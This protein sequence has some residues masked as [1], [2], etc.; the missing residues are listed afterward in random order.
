M[1]RQGR[2]LRNRDRRYPEPACNNCFTKEPIGKGTGKKQHRQ[3]SINNIVVKAKREAGEISYL[4]G[5]PFSAFT[6][7]Q[8]IFCK[9]Q[10]AGLFH[11]KKQQ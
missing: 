6:K 3:Q 8:I 9:S 1:E 4:S 2:Q 7:C 11:E 10:H 5:F